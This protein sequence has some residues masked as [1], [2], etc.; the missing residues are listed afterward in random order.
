MKA[1]DYTDDEIIQQ[2]IEV[3]CSEKKASISLLQRRL[4]LG[5][6]S[7]AR[8]MDELEKRG[9]VGSSKGAEP[10]DILI[11]IE[12]GTL[13][14]ST[15]VESSTELNV[16]YTCPNC[17]KECSVLESSTGQN[18][19]CPN[20]SREFYASPINVKTL[21]PDISISRTRYILP[22]KLPF[23]KS[24]RKQLLAARFAELAAYGQYN[25]LARQELTC[26]AAELDLPQSDVQELQEKQMNKEFDLIK[27]HIQS[28]LMLS[29]EDEKNIYQLEIKYG[30]KLF[31]GGNI[32]LLRASYKIALKRQL[33]HPVQ[34]GLMLNDSEV[35]YYR[36][37]TTWN[38]TRVGNYSYEGLSLSI[39]IVKGLNYRIAS[40]DVARTET[41][42]PLSAG[43][44][45]VTSERLLFIGESRNT[46][47]N[48]SR[49]VNF[50]IFMD[51]LKIEKSTGKSD[52]FTMA[53]E[54]A[55][56]IARL[57]GVIRQP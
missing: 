22:A 24:G 30:S 37:Q 48:L 31:L 6:N 11:D 9:V 57:I 3:I 34:T 28:V 43:V 2:C 18:V 1:N 33:P 40:Y 13:C 14:S 17:S 39:P 7:A 42:T 20:C 46:S 36:V 23:F 50:Q 32:E 41:M 38:Q 26:M 55:G 5:Y 8:I 21:Q 27:K 53:A 10:R 12:M 54:Q 35:A 45:Y 19:V 15:K 52:L 49:I 4:R 51:A 25:E 16:T 56:Y 29:D 44:L 47:I